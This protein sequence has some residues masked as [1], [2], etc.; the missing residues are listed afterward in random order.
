MGKLTLPL[1]TRYVLSQLAEFLFHR[2][3]IFLKNL[4]RL[5][6]GSLLFPALDE[7]RFELSENVGLLLDR[8]KTFLHQL[9]LDCAFLIRLL[10]RPE[11]SSQFLHFLVELDNFAFCVDIDSCIR[12]NLGHSSGPGWRVGDWQ[13]IDVS[14][15]SDRRQ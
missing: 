5:F 15:M 3:K 1:C 6:V 9:N 8:F 10:F 7:I 12:L 4:V 2:I 11:L 14:S 13:R